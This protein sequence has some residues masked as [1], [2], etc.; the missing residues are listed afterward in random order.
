MDKYGPRL[1]VSREA[2]A[3]VIELVDEEILDESVISD[4]AE[5]LFL[6]THDNPGGALL[7]SFEHVRY[8]SSGALGTLIR[9]NKRAEE[10]G[11]TLKLCHIRPS[12]YEIFAITKLNKLFDIYEN[13]EIALNSLGG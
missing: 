3:V 1:R 12:L 7:L 2:D 13:K 9:L 10:H 11:G 8:L 5:S 6:V 4:V